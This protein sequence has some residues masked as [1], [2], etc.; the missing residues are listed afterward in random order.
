MHM[1]NLAVVFGEGRGGVES[2]YACKTD[3]PERIY[4]GSDTAQGT[5]ARRSQIMGVFAR[6]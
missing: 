5:Y 6:R 2:S 3:Y 1:S 4:K